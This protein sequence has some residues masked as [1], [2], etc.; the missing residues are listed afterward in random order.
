MNLS[1]AF[2]I[3]QLWRRAYAQILEQ[4]LLLPGEEAQLQPAKDVIH[5]GFCESNLW[6]AGPAAG[7]EARVRELLAEKF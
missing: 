6:S 2:S 3:R 4:H 1:N 5:D 7:L